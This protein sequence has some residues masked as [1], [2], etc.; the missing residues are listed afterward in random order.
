MAISIPVQTNNFN[1]TYLLAQSAEAV[2]YTD[3]TPAE[4]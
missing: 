4:G 3:C 2:E 1:I